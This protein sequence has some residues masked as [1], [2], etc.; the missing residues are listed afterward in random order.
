[1]AT[2]TAEE[3]LIDQLATEVEAIDGIE[4]TYGFAQNPDTLSNAQ[5]PAALFLPIKFN[6]ELKAH[7][8]HHR[9]EIQITCVLF[10]AQRQTAGAKLKYLENRAIPFLS[11]F[12][13]RFQTEAV[14]QRLLAVGNLTTVTTFSG[15]YGAG[16]TYLTHNGIE[17]IGCIFTWT[18]IEII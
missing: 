3:N 13:A 18:F 15:T 5:L 10:V 4:S 11:K 1:M 17:H 16:G 6:A 7:H 2:R 12:R 14:I 9:N 8:N